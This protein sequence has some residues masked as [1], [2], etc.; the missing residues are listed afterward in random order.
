MQAV[1]LRRLD[2]G[3]KPTLQKKSIFYLVPRM[4][5]IGTAIALLLIAFIIKTQNTSVKATA[6]NYH[7]TNTGKA[8]QAARLISLELPPESG[9]PPEQFANQLLKRL[10][11]LSADCQKANCVALTFDDG[12]NSDSTPVILDALEAHLARATFFEIG[13]KVAGQDVILQ[14]IQADGDDIGNH[15]WSHPSFLTLNTNQ[16]KQQVSETQQAIEA[17][18]VT[19]PYLFRPPYGDYLLSMQKDIKMSVILWNVDPKD[20]AY[21][22]SAKIVKNVE[23]EIKPGAIIVMHDKPMTAKAMSKILTDL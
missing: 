21:T 14:R 9:S 23:Q 19:T 10:P 20:W 7:I 12:P 18:G 13:N 15:S 1:S 22:D 3:I 6:I 2:K 5:L 4:T 8:N 16:I 11:L 17:T